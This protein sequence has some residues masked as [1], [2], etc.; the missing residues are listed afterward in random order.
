MLDSFK[1]LHF[2]AEKTFYI[3]KQNI[4]DIS[5]IISLYTDHGYDYVERIY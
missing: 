4:S 3:S 1:H 2:N 5:S